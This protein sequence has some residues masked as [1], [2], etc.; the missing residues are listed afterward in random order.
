M[1][2][3]GF[4]DRI[5]DIP[6]AGLIGIN[7]DS[8][9]TPA[10][11]NVPPA[12]EQSATSVATPRLRQSQTTV[13]STPVDANV[14]PEIKTK[15]EHIA[16]SANQVSY[17]NFVKVLTP[18]RRALPGESEAY[19][20]TFAASGASGI[21]VSEILRGLDAITGDLNRT[22]DQFNAA[23]PGQIEKKV[24]ARKTRITG[25]KDEKDGKANRLKQLQDEVSRLSN[26]LSQ[27][28]M[29]IQ[30]EDRAIEG[31]RAA[32]MKDASIFEATFQAVMAPY[33]EERRRIEQYG[34]E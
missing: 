24:S 15:L 11:S 7:P 23:V 17:T 3:R 10:P 27:L 34:K 32:V 33:V 28:D 19:R 20:A 21:S 18:M 12:V 4:L 9:A 25:L 14:D 30:Q 2:K 1:A 8:E 16:A 31:D 26:E 22:R 6:G 13:V 29:Q 5:A